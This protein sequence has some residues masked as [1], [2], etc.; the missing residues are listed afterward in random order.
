MQEIQDEALAIRLAA[1]IASK[2]ALEDLKT[3][4]SLPSSASSSRQRIREILQKQRQ[5]GESRGVE[6]KETE[7]MASAAFDPSRSKLLWVFR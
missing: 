5:E 7:K 4:P 6:D 2:K 3:T 1:D